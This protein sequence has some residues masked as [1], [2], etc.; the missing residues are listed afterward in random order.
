MLPLARPRRAGFTLIELL[1]VIAIIAILTA[2]L[3]P[4]FFAA[5]E[6]A[7]QG[8]VMDDFRQIN[9][10]L[11]KYKLD[12]HRDPDVLFGFAD[13]TKSMSQ[14]RPV[15][16]LYPQYINDPT[17]FM[18]PNNTVTDPTKTQSVASNSLVGGALT[19]INPTP[20]YYTADAYDIS[21]Q[22]DATG[23]A[24]SPINYIPRYQRAWTNFPPPAGDPNNLPTNPHELA[25]PT[26]PDDTYVT[27]TTY[28][29]GPGIG[30]GKVLVLFAGGNARTIDTSRFLAAA[31]GTDG[32]G[33]TD[34]FWEITP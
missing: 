25:N 1:V 2:I 13:P 19:P 28:H 7:R 29:A 12:N 26:P 14:V 11:A 9:G 23:K 33:T 5:K 8:T 30:Q 20:L 4:V 27:C 31:G 21:P 17:V 32:P 16:S 34:K 3:F 10:A 22:I 15:G 6:K 18:D 24:V